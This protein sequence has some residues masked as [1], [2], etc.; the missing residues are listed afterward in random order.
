MMLN[1][2]EGQMDSWISSLFVP[3]SSSSGSGAGAGRGRGA[4]LSKPPSS[5]Q[6]GRGTRRVSGGS[7]LEKDVLGAA[8][9]GPVAVSNPE[10]TNGT[11]VTPERIAQMMKSVEQPQRKRRSTILGAPKLRP[12]LPVLCI[13]PPY[14]GLESKIIQVPSK[15]NVA[16]VINYLVEV[17]GGHFSASGI[18]L[19]VS[20]ND[21]PFEDAFSRSET[22]PFLDPKQPLQWYEEVISTTP[23]YWERINREERPVGRSNQKMSVR[24]KCGNNLAKIEIDAFEMSVTD[25]EALASKQFVG[26]KNIDS[27]RLRLCLPRELEH[28][29]D[30]NGE[31][32]KIGMRESPSYPYLEHGKMIAQYANLLLALDYIEM[33]YGKNK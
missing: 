4:G 32:L 27:S 29:P 18:G 3:G 33:A 25:V 28:L 24:V 2:D 30:I 9:V 7:N 14:L 22:F 8:P 31:I 15:L 26:L 17:H 11:G 19:C 10:E 23:L 6:A 16:G 5:S 21:Y 20:P 1:N 13:F 12:T